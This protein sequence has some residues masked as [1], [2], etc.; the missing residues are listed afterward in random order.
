MWCTHTRIPPSQ[1]LA[2]LEHVT[3]E[4]V[5]VWLDWSQMSER[6]THPPRSGQ[7]DA[8]LAPFPYTGPP[9]STQ[10]VSV[11]SKTVF[12][13]PKILGRCLDTNIVA[14]EGDEGVLQHAARLQRANH[15]ADRIVQVVHHAV[16][17]GPPRQ[18]QKEDHHHHQAQQ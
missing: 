5:W 8:P 16:P 11:S 10:T 12:D 14:A 2:F 6:G 7:F 18:Q 4:R 17:K 1:L 15:S 3:T 13:R 9:C